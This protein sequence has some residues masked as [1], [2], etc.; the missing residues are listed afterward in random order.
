MSPELVSSAE[1]GIHRT[2][3]AAVVLLAIGLGTPGILGLGALLALVA[4]AKAATQK[5]RPDRSDPFS[6]PSGHTAA[7]AFLA[8]AYGGTMGILLGVWAIGVGISRMHRRRHDLADVA[9]GALLG[10]WCGL[11][12]RARM[13]KSPLVH[14]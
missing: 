1:D 11:A 4:L 10:L 13:R 9:A 8:A 2:Y 14:R 7:A 3:V 12:V 5:V 6:F